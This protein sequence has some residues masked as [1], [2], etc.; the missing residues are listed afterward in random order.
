MFFFFYISRMKWKYDN[1]KSRNDSHV[2]LEVDA[3]N[4]DQ[5]HVISTNDTSSSSISNV[6]EE[7]NHPYNIN[8][9]N[10]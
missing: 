5:N 6:K 9:N 3:T 8:E 7:N 10:K 2:K 1:L 4:D